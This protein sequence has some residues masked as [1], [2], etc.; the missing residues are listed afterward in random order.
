MGVN[1]LIKE[2]ATP[3]TSYKDILESFGIEEEAS[4]SSQSI[5]DSD[6]ENLIL[7]ILDKGPAHI[8]N[9]SKESGLTPQ[10]TS[11]TV[12][13]L[14]VKGKIINQGAQTFALKK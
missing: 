12:S 9:L 3:V 1:N 6:M 7:S 11:S 4:A 10:E 14:E 13:L 5:G 2:G 8:D